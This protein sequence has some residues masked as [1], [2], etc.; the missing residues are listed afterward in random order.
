MVIAVA[1]AA[2]YA[3]KRSG[4]NQVVQ[5]STTM[6]KSSAKAAEKPGDKAVLPTAKRPSR[7]TK[8]KG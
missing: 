6:R 1:D 2:L 8:K 5:A 3:A 4:R 7:T